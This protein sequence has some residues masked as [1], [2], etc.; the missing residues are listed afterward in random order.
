MTR[1]IV[2]RQVNVVAVNFVRRRLV[3]WF[4]PFQLL[5]LDFSPVGRP[6]D[7][8][9]GIVITQRMIF[10]SIVFVA[11]MLH[12]DFDVA[13]VIAGIFGVVIALEVGTVEVGL[14]GISVVTFALLIYNKNILHKLPPEARRAKNGFWRCPTLTFRVLNSPLPSPYPVPPSTSTITVPSIFPRGQPFCFLLN[15][16]IPTPSSSPS[17]VSAEAARIIK[18]KRD[19]GCTDFPDGAV[20]NFIQV[21]HCVTG[22][23]VSTLK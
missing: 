3:L 21:R 5:H 17:T 4:L 22:I 13:V 20:L 23:P 11:G 10:G 15:R 7:H 19:A 18:T 2:C 6:T 9:M 1:C 14:L 12:S 16:P 8:V